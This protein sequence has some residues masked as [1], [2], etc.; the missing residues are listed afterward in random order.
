MSDYPTKPPEGFSIER[1]PAN[2]HKYLPPEWGGTPW[3]L[4]PAPPTEDDHDR[5]VGNGVLCGLLGLTLPQ[6]D[7]AKRLGMPFAQDAG[8]NYIYSLKACTDFVRRHEDEVLYGI[9]P[10]E[11]KAAH[12]VTGPVLAQ[13]LG[14]SRH[15]VLRW[16]GKGM[17]HSVAAN[18]AYLYAPAA[19]MAWAKGRKLNDG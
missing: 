5:V 7:R 15:R 13:R 2:L 6:L 10:A 9:R 11:A 4:K 19:C 8:R 16:A 14:I 3:E 12:Y 18:G 1:Y 17:P